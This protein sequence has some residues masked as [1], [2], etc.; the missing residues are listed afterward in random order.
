MSA[1]AVPVHAFAAASDSTPASSAAV[2]GTC[3]ACGGA[4][5][6]DFCHACG[7]RRLR[8]DEMTLRA[9]ARDVA[10]E[11]G[12]LDSRAARSLRYLVT[13]PGF[14]T[15]E[16]VAGRR[17]AYLG[18]LKLFIAA[19]AGVLLVD[20]LLSRP[21]TEEAAAAVQASWAGGIV[22]AVGARR[23]TSRVE[24]LEQL[25]ATSASHLSWLSLLIPVMLAAVLALV[26]A[27]RGRGY[28]EHMVFAAHAATFSLL[29]ELLVT[30]LEPVI[31]TRPA[32]AV[33]LIMLLTLGLMWLYLWRA[34]ARVYGDVRWRGAW[35]AGVLV[36][37]F[38]MAQSVAGLLATATATLS[39]LYL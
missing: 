7:E 14:L 32:V 6:G 9:F 30:P 28:V 27:R 24:T 36:L 10:S 5:L 37:G 26:F 22:N 19:Y 2:A 20:R 12:D 4:L 3:T 31:V 21:L 23:G 1:P 29:L 11:V 13:R 15:A 35:R 16:F 34:V 8:P 33:P 25:A 39:L 18:P 38:T 17:R